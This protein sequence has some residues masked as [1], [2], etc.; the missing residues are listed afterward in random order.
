MSSDQNPYEQI[1]KF[2]AEAII[3]TLIS[4]RVI[5]TTKTLN[6]AY[7]FIEESKE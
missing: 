2:L 3:L 4:L 5:V 1:F 6:I 7:E